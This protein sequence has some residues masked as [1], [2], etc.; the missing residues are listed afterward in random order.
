[1]K[2][3][4]VGCGPGLITL[5]AIGEIRKASKVYG[6]SRAIDLVREHIP[7]GCEVKA[8]SDYR[9]IGALPGDAVLLSTGDPMLA[10]LGDHGTV[11]VPGISSMQVAFA[12]LRLPLS[13]AAVAMAHGRDHKV[14]MQSAADDLGRGK[15][16]FLIVEP[17]FDIKRLGSFLADCGI[18]CDIALCEELGYPGERITIGTTAVPPEPESR[19]FSL[20]L[21]HLRRS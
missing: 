19:L 21:G 5:E 1:M 14:A 15:I 12:R 20:L 10:G 4:G 16:V 18:C 7:E 11:V 17:G 13:Q 8:I 2:V 3:I 9:N 6:S